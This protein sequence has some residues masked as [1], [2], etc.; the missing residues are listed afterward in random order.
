MDYLLFNSLNSFLTAAIII[1]L[2]QIIY[3]AIGFGSAMISITM[4]SIIFGNISQIIPYFL[5]LCVPT[6]III[7][8]RNRH[9][10]DF[11]FLKNFLLYLF[12]GL[13]IG[14]L[15][16][17]F[18]MPQKLLIYLGLVII[19]IAF[20]FLLFENK[21]N[22]SFKKNGM[23]GKT[24]SF[25]SGILGGVYGISG[26]PIII[27][28]KG[29]KMDKSRFRTTILSVFFAMSIIRTFIYTLLGLYNTKIILSVIATLPF[30]AAGIYIGNKIH[31]IISETRF[32]KITAILLLING[33]ILVLKHLK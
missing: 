16:L 23:A 18:T 27:F 25:L 5:L 32:K 6:E 8:S 7:V 20:Y 17:K 33:T 3:A 15:L 24:L 12:S 1:M 2:G 4:L 11:K 30:V 19:V 21:M 9:F 22:P 31:L 28:L 26:P 13:L 29:L 14:S 10:L